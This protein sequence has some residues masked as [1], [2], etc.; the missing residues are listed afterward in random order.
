MLKVANSVINASQI[1]GVLPVVNGGTSVTTSTGTGDTVLSASPTF[2]GTAVF[3]ALSGTGYSFSGSAAANSLALDS[4]GNLR[5]G[6]VTSSGKITADLAGGHILNVE[7]NGTTLG[8][9]NGVLLSNFLSQTTRVA[10]INLSAT[11]SD[12]GAIILGTASGGT[13]AERARIDSSGNVG[14][15][16]TTAVGRLTVTSAAS[17]EYGTFDAPTSGYAF[18][19]LRYNGTSYGNI[20]QGSAVVTG[21]V[22]TDFGLNATTNMLFATGGIT[23]RMRIDSSGNLLV[24]TTATTGSASNNTIVAGGKFKTVS[25]SV[26]TANNTATTLF[27]A[28]T[29]L[30]AWLVTVNVD[31]DSVLYAATYIVNTQGGSS[32]VAT[33]IYKGTL[34]SI[35]VSGYDVKATQTS[36]GTETIQYSAVRIF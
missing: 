27:T 11:A 15:G 8:S 13:L 24:G 19:R 31:A 7:L 4:T 33:I 29:T 23:E 16:T 35:S 36:G 2:S 6:V 3:A 12:A 5:V 14:I 22:A 25:G 34:I 9:T 20:G 1:T 26:S 10:A 18:L 17:Q 32:T 21:G 30:G 28:P